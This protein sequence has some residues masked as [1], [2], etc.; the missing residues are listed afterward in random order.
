MKDVLSAAT[1]TCFRF[2]PTDDAKYCFD[3]ETL[4]QFAHTIVDD[5]NAQF[6][7]LINERSGMIKTH[8]ENITALRKE[9]SDLKAEVRE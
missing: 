2:H 6:L 9:L 8:R 5:M 1:R 3:D 7:S 4:L